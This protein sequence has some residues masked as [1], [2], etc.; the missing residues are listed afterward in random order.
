MCVSGKEG[1]VPEPTKVESFHPCSCR[2]ARAVP[3]HVRL[4]TAHLVAYRLKIKPRIVMPRM[5]RTRRLG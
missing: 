3:P 2:T 4:V 1:A 5:K